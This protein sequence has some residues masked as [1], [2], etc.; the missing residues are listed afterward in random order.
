MVE[1]DI[2]DEGWWWRER[3][4]HQGGDVA[5]TSSWL[6]AHLSEGMDAMGIEKELVV[7]AVDTLTE[8]AMHVVT[9]LAW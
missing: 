6:V 1:H 9:I 7:V 5:S 8:S 2:M 4:W 3:A